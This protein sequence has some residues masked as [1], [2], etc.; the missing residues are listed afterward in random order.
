[1]FTTMSPLRTAL[2]FY[3]MAVALVTVVALTGGSTSAAMLTPV[4]SVLLMLLL[5]TRE[6]WSRHGWASLGLHRLGLR[7]WPVAILVPTLVFTLAALAMVVTGTASWQPEGQAAGVPMVLWPGVFLI[8]IAFASLTVSLTEE[9]GWR[10]YFL[11]RLTPLGERRA[12]VLSGLLHGVWHL[13]VILLTSLYLADGSPLVVVPMF[14]A[15]VTAGGVF[16]GW[17]RLRTDSVWPAVIAHSAHNVS[18]AWV[19]LLLVGDAHDMERLGGESGIVPIVAYVAVAAVLLHRS[20]TS[21][22]LS[23]GPVPGPVDQYVTTTTR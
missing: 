20:G 22:R 16:M 13:P 12:L 5:V 23:A 1:M 6:G 14:L 15:C 8:N 7:S 9:I 21:T 2:V 11:P 3:A 17:L 19:A 18:V 10:G 4:L